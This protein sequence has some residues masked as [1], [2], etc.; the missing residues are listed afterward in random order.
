MVG[1]SPNAAY[2]HMPEAYTQRGMPEAEK[3]K[4]FRYSL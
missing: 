3:R 1:M 4:M 2:D